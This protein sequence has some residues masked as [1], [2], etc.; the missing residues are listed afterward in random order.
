M[1][2][3]GVCNSFNLKCSC[4]DRYYFHTHS[5]IFNV[6]RLIYNMLDDKDVL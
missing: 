4:L 5:H 6:L 3:T 2:L 1:K